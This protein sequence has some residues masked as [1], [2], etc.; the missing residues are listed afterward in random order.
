MAQ[1]NFGANILKAGE[2]FPDRWL[3]QGLG[4][5]AFLRHLAQAT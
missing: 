5:I 1:T 3:C 2:Q 4:R